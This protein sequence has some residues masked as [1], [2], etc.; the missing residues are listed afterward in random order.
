M[1]QQPP[2]TTLASIPFATRVATM[3]CAA[4]PNDV[5]IGV[6]IM[7]P[8]TAAHPYR[9]PNHINPNFFQVICPVG[10]R[11]ARPVNNSKLN[12]KIV[13]SPSEKNKAPPIP[14]I[15]KLIIQPNEI[16][17]PANIEYILSSFPD[18]LYYYYNTKFQKNQLKGEIIQMK[19]FKKVAFV[20]LTL[21]IF[22]VCL[23]GCNENL[24]FGNYS[25]TH[26]HYSDG[27]EGHCAKVNSWHDNEVG[28]E[29][30]TPNGTIYVSEGTYQLFE[31]TETCPYCK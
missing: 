22:A 8:A 21:I 11:P 25:F 24:G 17:I 1:P 30:H 19:I 9:L 18:I 23:T 29:V 6:S 14:P 13:S 12:I 15:C 10:I 26:I 20:C 7:A 2:S 27:I 28:C 16:I 31:K 4:I 3:N 5:P